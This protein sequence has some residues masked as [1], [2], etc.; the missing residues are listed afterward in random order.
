MKTESYTT[1]VCWLM[2]PCLTIGCA[3]A[4]N[5]PTQSVDITSEPAGARAT[6]QPIDH[7]VITP[8]AVGLPRTQEYQV[9]FEL[10]GYEPQ[11][12]LLRQQGSG[13]VAGNL[14]FGGLIGVAVDESSGAA[15]KLVPDPLHKSLQRLLSYYQQQRQGRS[16]DL[17]Y[18][19]NLQNT[20]VE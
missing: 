2:V 9:R 6:I 3:T 7:T 20:L 12:L 19:E 16:I 4:I 11:M 13:A 17:M 1:A 18:I 14:L 8:A 15:Y 5:G 10:E